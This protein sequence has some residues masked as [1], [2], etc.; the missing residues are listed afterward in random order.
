[1]SIVVVALLSP[2][3]LT[4]DYL[5]PENAGWGPLAPGHRVLVPFGRSQRI[6]IVVECKDGSALAGGKLK[7][8]AAAL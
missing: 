4:F 5:V 7:T 8:V 2:L 1:M 3:R 6:G